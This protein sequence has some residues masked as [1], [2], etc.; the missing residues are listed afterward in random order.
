MEELIEV[1]AESTETSFPKVITYNK[2]NKLLIANRREIENNFQ[3]DCPYFQG[4]NPQCNYYIPFVAETARSESSA[5]AAATDSD[6]VVKAPTFLE[7]I[8][9][10]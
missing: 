10:L 8:D 7:E 1:S 5:E 2:L 6:Q 9:K 3:K 4:E